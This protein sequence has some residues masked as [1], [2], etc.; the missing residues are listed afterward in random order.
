MTQLL[1]RRAVPDIMI[2]FIAMG[3]SWVMGDSVLAC[4]IRTLTCL[5]C[6]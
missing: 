5:R 2:L 4:L 6:A 1:P 3:V